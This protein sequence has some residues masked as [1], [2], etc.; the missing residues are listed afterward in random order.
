MKK[1]N[2][3]LCLVLA[4][5]ILPVAGCSAAQQVRESVNSVV[6]QATNFEY[7]NE[8]A[9]LDNAMRVF[10]SKV[11]SGE[12][13]SVTAGNRVSAPLPPQNA[14]SSERKECA[15]R[16]PLYS[17]IEEQGMTA[18]FTDEK[19][20]YMVCCEN[21]IQ[22]LYSEKI[23]GKNHFPISGSTPLGDILLA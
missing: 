3:L 2:I 22:Y 4:A 1:A 18:R 21:K 13:N 14:S 12:L 10:Y 16:L 5:A 20:S 6:G 15:A 19:L 11:V 8:A 23:K 9:A 7:E 17:V